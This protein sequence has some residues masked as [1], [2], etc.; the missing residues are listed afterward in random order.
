MPA[1]NEVA[2]MSE[3]PMISACGFRCDLCPAFFKNE[4]GPEYQAEIAAGWKNYYDIDMAAEKIICD[5]CRAE[6]A[7]GRELPARECKTR[8]CV[9]DKDLENCAHCDEYPCGHREVTMSGVEKSRD[10]HVGSISEEERLKF[11]EP[12][13]ARRNF[14]EIRRS[15]T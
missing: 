2:H 7:P 3:E 8:D 13:E 9:A 14:E 15:L 4:M 6:I 10:N 5:G 1:R 12:Y 11:F